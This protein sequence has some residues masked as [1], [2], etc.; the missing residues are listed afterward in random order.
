M[1]FCFSSKLL[2]KSV[3]SSPLVLNIYQALAETL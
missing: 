3:L 2:G 1:T